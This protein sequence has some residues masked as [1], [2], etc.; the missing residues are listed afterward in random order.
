MSLEKRKRNNIVL[1]TSD[2]GGRCHAFAINRPWRADDLETFC[3]I[4]FVMESIYCALLLCSSSTN[5]E[6]DVCS[7]FSTLVNAHVSYMDL[8][9]RQEVER[10]SERERGE[11]VMYNSYHPQ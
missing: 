7:S 8:C 11:G 9:R 4:I 6:R 5:N 2:D 10:E 1:H 3:T